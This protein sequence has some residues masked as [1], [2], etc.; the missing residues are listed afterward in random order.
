MKL[1]NDDEMKRIVGGSW[2]HAVNVCETVAEDDKNGPGTCARLR[3]PFLEGKISVERAHCG[4]AL[5]DM[6]T[7]DRVA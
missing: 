3:R 7:G 1:L 2:G 6:G 5:Q 4:P